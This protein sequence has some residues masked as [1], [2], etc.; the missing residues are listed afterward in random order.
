MKNRIPP[1]ASLI[2]FENEDYIIINKP[3][4]ISSLQ[5]RVDELNILKLAKKYHEQA[6][7]CHRLDKQTSGILIISKNEEAYKFVNQQFEKRTIEKEYHAISHGLHDFRNLEIDKPLSIHSNGTARIDMRQGKRSVTLLN[8][9]RAFRKHTLINCI[10]KTGRM[11]QIRV[12]LAYLKAPIVGDIA[13]GGEPFYLSSIK[14][15]YKISKFAEEQPLIHRMALH[16]YRIGFKLLSGDFKEVIA[17]YPKD[18]RVLLN[19]LEK[20]M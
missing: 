11:H 14:R 16:A 19:Q 12:H 10:P 15:N 1:F 4:F 9:M 2:L 6:Q 7:L 8:S 20:N 5:D 17:P 13:Y 18:F 3:P